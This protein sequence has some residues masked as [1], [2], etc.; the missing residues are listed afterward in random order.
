[1]SNGHA[2]VWNGIFNYIN[3]EIRAFNALKNNDGKFII[4]L[5]TPQIPTI[6]EKKQTIYKKWLN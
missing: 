1:M 6:Y 3:S 2:I 4:R 5:S